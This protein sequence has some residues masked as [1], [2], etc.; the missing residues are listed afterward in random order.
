VV[1]NESEHTQYEI[2]KKTID[3]FY[4]NLPAIK[5]LKDLIDKRITERGYLIG[6]DGRKLQIRSRHS[7][8][9]NYCNQQ[10]L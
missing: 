9:I 10:E 6:I 2:G 7:A 1:P 8:L 5:Q 3:T 4:K